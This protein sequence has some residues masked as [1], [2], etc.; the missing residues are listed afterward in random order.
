MNKKKTGSYYTPI[1]I[2]DFMVKYLFKKIKTKNIDILEPSVGDGVFVRSLLS[3]NI[4]QFTTK[5]ITILDINKEELLKAEITL[6]INNSFDKQIILNED[7][8]D[9]Q[10]NSNHYS[11]IIGNPPYINRKLLS[12]ETIER[13]EL[14]HKEAILSSFKINNIWTSFVI[15]GEKLLRDDGVMAYVLPAD[16]LQVKYAEE[17]RELLEKSFD[18]LEILTLD[19]SVFPEIEQQTIILIAFKKSKKPGTFFYQ[20]KDLEKVKVAQTSSNGLMISQSKWTH[21]NLT[22]IEI[23]LLN[24]LTS[25]LPK[26]SDFVDI[27]SGI[28][29]GANSFFIQPQKVIEKYELLDTAIPI[30]NKSIHINYKVDFTSKDFE[31]LSRANKAVYLVSINESVGLREKPNS[32]LKTGEKHQINTRYKC[33]QREHWY[34]VPNI[35]IPSEAF[36]FRRSHLYPKIVKNSA[37]VYVTDSS[38][39]VNTKPNSD[40]KSFIYSFYNIITLIYAELMGRKYGGGVLELTP[41]EFKDL[42]IIHRQIDNSVFSDFKK[43]VSKG[44]DI[45]TM[46][47]N[48]RKINTGFNETVNS[49]E[50]LQLNQI[51]NK[52]VKARITS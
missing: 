1:E 52:L 42:P 16:I 7:F 43:L 25:E 47:D 12:K 34:S 38:Y 30:I 3:N 9:F 4:E 44:D 46:I 21:Y 49:K 33:S 37:K 50:I 40:I 10:I 45:L 35:S 14:I 31:E 29:T 26:I 27:S 5:N 39:K 13:C 24:K 32:Y 8:L 15:A 23:N 20:I 6:K 48:K 28:V 17:I 51:Y 18:R 41:N 2:S 11:L 22:S 36:F 19:T